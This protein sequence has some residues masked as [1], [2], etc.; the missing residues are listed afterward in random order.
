MDDLLKTFVEKRVAMRTQ[1]QPIIGSHAQVDEGRNRIQTDIYAKIKNMILHKQKQNDKYLKEEKIRKLIQRYLLKISK[2]QTGGGTILPDDIT[3][4]I[5]EFLPNIDRGRYA[6]TASVIRD[7]RNTTLPDEFYTWLQDLFNQENGL[8]L[9]TEVLD[10]LQETPDSLAAA[11]YKPDTDDAKQARKRCV[12]LYSA[13]KNGQN[14]YNLPDAQDDEE[15]V[16]AAV[17]MSGYAFR[18]ASKRLQDNYD[19]AMA[20]VMMSGYAFRHAS[21]RLQDNYDIAMAAVTQNG[22]VL[23]WAS[24]MIKAEP[25]VVLA[26]VTNNGFAL[27]YA[28]DMI[29]ADRDVVLV[30]VAN[31]GDSLEWA[32]DALKGDRD[33]VLA[34]LQQNGEALYFATDELKGDRDVVL[35]A[36]NSVENALE[37]A[38]EN[39]RGD[40]KF[41]TEITEIMPNA[42]AYATPVLKKFLT[43][44][45]VILI[46]PDA[47][48]LLQ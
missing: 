21:K 11:V 33:V 39:L 26:A 5:N 8:F 47:E 46:P 1:S 14:L 2:I 19:I 27:E 22:E 20:A 4:R 18:H 13:K 42:F 45:R 17:M 15:I 25:K 24:D 6:E 37:F 23:E 10:M 36:V 9:V 40:I 7:T 32:S 12:M 28:S 3:R 30:A 34:A 16:M 44:L 29:K 41:M 38:S 35:A 48:L 43:K 31:L